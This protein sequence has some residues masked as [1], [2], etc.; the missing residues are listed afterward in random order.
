MTA[1]GK[2]HS[3]VIVGTVDGVDVI[4]CSVCGFI[5]INPL[6]TPT[7]LEELYKKNFYSVDKPTFI[8][9][10]GEDKEWLNQQYSDRYDTFELELGDSRKR[11]ILDVGSGP[12]FFL[13]YGQERGWD[14]LG[15]E[16]STQACEHTKSLGINV[17]NECFDVNSA[18][19]LGKFD[20]IHASLVLEHIPN[21]IECVQL[22]FEH[23]N[24]G[25]I[26]C[27]TAPNDFNP[28]Q[29]ALTAVE[30]YAPWWIVPKHHLNYFTPDSL[31]FLM[32]RVG[33]DIFLKETSFP[34]D[35]FL[36]MGD[37]YIGNEQL[38]RSCHHKRVRFEAN[39]AHAGL[40]ELKRKLYRSLAEINL[41]REIC[42]YG[43][44]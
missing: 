21:P 35:M 13:K 10:Q 39:L 30:D 32:Q 16:P 28:F 42:V 7:E 6:P 40:N 44:K 4:D 15:I 3:G 14:V 24:D 11:K 2:E 29:K 22:M 18:K 25:G 38:G 9:S 23:L 37:N 43:R 8:S 19:H 1:Q 27:I 20:V 33:L 17:L 36:L 5:H 12:G 34:I 26:M 31:S 41:G